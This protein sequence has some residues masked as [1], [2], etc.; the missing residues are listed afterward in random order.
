PNIRKS[1]SAIISLYDFVLFI[2]KDEIDEDVNVIKEELLQILKYGSGE[3][4]SQAIK[5]FG[6]FIER[7]LDIVDS[8]L[9]SILIIYLN[10]F[11]ITIKNDESL[12]ET[13]EDFVL[14]ENHAKLVALMVEY[15]SDDVG[16]SFE[17]WKDYI[18]THK[19]PEVKSSIIHFK[20]K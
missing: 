14:L 18:S 4:L 19:L 2:N 17:E 20:N 1:K 5:V 7:N 13:R 3:R 8:S 10:R 16:T 9:A 6:D 11:L 12:I 15:K